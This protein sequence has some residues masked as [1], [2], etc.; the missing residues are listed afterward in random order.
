MKKLKNGNGSLRAHARPAPERFRQLLA[1]SGLSDEEL[2]VKLEVSAS[3]IGR[4]RRGTSKPRR[5]YMNLAT[6][7]LQEIR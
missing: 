4:W 3:T 2:A 1:A 5:V 7:R 6:E